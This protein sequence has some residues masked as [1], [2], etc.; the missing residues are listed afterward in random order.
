MNAPR[1]IAGRVKSNVLSTGAIL[2]VACNT[3]ALAGIAWKGAQWTEHV[4]FQQTILVTEQKRQTDLLDRVVLT[5][6]QTVDQIVALEHRV[7]ELETRR[8]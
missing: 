6:Q 8:R 5:Q 4:N 3:L 2:T 7:R 1:G